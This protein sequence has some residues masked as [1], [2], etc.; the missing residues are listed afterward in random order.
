[1]TG[2]ED[3][4]ARLT[5][6]ADRTAPPPREGLAGLVVARHRSQR[7]QTLG[8]AAVAAAVAGLVVLSSTVVDSGS[9]AEPAPAISADAAG[10]GW[11]ADVL[12]DPARGSL[13]D[14][15][16]FAEG[17]RELSWTSGFARGDD[18]PDPPLDTRRVLFAG[19]VGDSRLALI[20]GLDPAPPVEGS[21]RPGDATE[22]SD[23]V[24]TWFVGPSGASPSD[25]E[26]ATPPSTADAYGGPPALVVPDTGAVVVVGRPGDA[27]SLSL[28]PEV[29]ADGQVEREFEPVDAP[30]GVATLDLP[31]VAGTGQALGYRVVRGTETWT[32]NLV[33][34]GSTGSPP[35]VTA[36]QLRTA[37][38]PSPMDD[39]VAQSD[40][41]QRLDQLGLTAE[42]VDVAV[43]WAGDVP[44]PTETP[45]RVTVVGM[46]LP[47]GA[48]LV[49]CSLGL[50]FADGSG[51]G[52]GCGSELRPAGTPLTEQT[53]VLRS[54]A[55]DFR[56]NQEVVSSLVVVAPVGTVSARAL[57]S[58][59]DVL[60]EFPL[61]D[62][63]GVVAFPEGTA[64]VETLAADGSIL[65]REQPLT[66]ADLGD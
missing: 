50:D 29:A 25:L 45:S 2:E 61:T 47:S 39:G 52:T 55:S 14:D 16:A 28:R 26:L 23:V 1:M 60:A 9:S 19:D 3:L 8:I 40:V 64:A 54:D 48:V 20:A 44:S 32:S 10:P 49:Q 42:D 15:A 13:A 27:V 5:R 18:V 33:T 22:L 56:L 12:A 58:D 21:V 35:A 31:S 38:P 17:V 51:A 59:G 46:T 63:V 4:Q 30:D 57:D 65:E 34:T 43:V 11:A 6:L 66:T 24:L 36:T 62:G 41:R 53:V 37:S 7:R